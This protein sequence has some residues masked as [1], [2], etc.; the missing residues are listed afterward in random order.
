MAIQDRFPRQYKYFATK[1]FYYR[2][3]AIGN[4]NRLLGRV[5]GVDG[6][7]TGYTRASGFNLL[8]SMKR[9]GRFVIGVVL[10]GSSGA[11]R[12]ARMASLI[13]NNYNRAYAG[14]RTTP[15]VT[16]TAALATSP[17]PIPA[18]APAREV[19][20]PVAPL[21]NPQHLAYAADPVTTA[22]VTQ[23]APS[24]SAEP[25]KPLGVKTVAIQRPTTQYLEAP[26]FTSSVSTPP[27]YAAAAGSLVP[28][29]TLSPAGSLSSSGTLTAAPAPQPMPQSQQ[30]IRTASA[31]P[32]TLP[33]SAMVPI[34]AP[35]A[36]APA[37]AAAAPALAPVRNEPARSAAQ[38]KA[39]WQIQIG[40]FSAEKEA[41]AKLDVAQAKAKQ[42]LGNAD[43]FTEKVSTG[44]AALYRARF[45]GLD[46]KDAKAACRLLQR[47]D[48]ACMT[49]RN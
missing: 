3:E 13:A 16:E 19:R 27:T 32:I 4:H 25:I 6:I 24:G 45:A 12:D 41:R 49:L 20:G 5:E 48:F 26:G 47:N 44:G 8:T 18:A 42:L 30:P 10:G 38:H 28:P 11:S 43:P 22:T 1:T 39:G 2:G 40:A 46:E 14:A 21:P 31:G 35:V 37:R 34:S 33:A 7:K 15:Q 9:D 29:A 23:R 36:A 17:A